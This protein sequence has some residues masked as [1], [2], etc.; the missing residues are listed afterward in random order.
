MSIGALLAKS[1]HVVTFTRA[2][3]DETDMGTRDR[4]MNPLEPL[5]IQCWPQPISAHDLTEFAQRDITVTHKIYIGVDIDL[6]EGDIANVDCEEEH[7]VRGVRD[8]SAG[9]GTLF[10]VDVDRR[11]AS[12]S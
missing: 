12:G 8:A 5:D 11:K 7:I 6:R 3:L 2:T 4:T 9:L 1:K 10:R